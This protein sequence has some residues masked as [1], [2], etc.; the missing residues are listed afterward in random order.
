MCRAM[1][2]SPA[3]ADPDGLGAALAAQ[4]FSQAK[5]PVDGKLGIDGEQTSMS[6][7]MH[8]ASAQVIFSI[9]P[10]IYFCPSLVH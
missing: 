5:I 3:I 4:C 6:F 1:S 7:V 8:P 2:L 9:A 10:F